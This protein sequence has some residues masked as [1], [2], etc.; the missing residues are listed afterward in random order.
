MF[1]PRD[2]R[3]LLIS[4]ACLVCAH[5]MGSAQSM[6]QETSDA[7]ST[8]A[9]ITGI[10][11]LRNGNVL[12]GKIQR[13]SDFYRIKLPHSELQIRVDQVDTF[14][15]NLD[16]AYEQRRRRRT[17]GSADS[18]VDLARWCLRH[19]LL[20]FASRELLEARLIDPSHRQ[21]MLLERQLQLALQNQAASRAPK[22]LTSIAIKQSDEELETLES[23]PDWA[24]TL[25]VRQIQP[26][27]VDSCA[28]SGCHQP[29][30]TDSFHLNRLAREGAG[31]PATTERNLAA[32]LSQLDLKS[33]AKS[34]LLLRARTAHGAV[35]G[36]P[37]K[38]HR[39]K[40][41][42]TWV[43]QLS[44]AKKNAPVKEI[45]LVSHLTSDTSDALPL[46]RRALDESVAP[47]TDPFDPEQFNSRFATEVEATRQAPTAPAASD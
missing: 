26:L 40:M 7:Q 23:V 22:P 16:E 3:L 2:L 4:Y 33:P 31:H 25:F 13:Q 1:W 39:Y 41:L 20:E 42:L 46:I 14:C 15:H 32:T 37:L 44:L 45:E 17:G 43:E 29:G 19:D 34:E 35:G 47:P 5:S 38:R 27:L 24:R 8:D 36:S 6:S 18:H 11:V 12:E 21:L 28:T 10:L 9:E 30:S